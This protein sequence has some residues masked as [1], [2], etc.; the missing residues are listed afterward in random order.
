MFTNPESTKESKH[1]LHKANMHFYICV[2]IIR[3]IGMYYRIIGM[4][5]RKSVV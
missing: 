1:N 4:G 5:D 3:Y 2:Y